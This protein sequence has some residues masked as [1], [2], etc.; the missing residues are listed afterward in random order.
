M[1]D[2]QE[3][4]QSNHFPEPEPSYGIG[5]IEE[6]ISEDIDRLLTN[7]FD[8]LYLRD[9]YKHENRSI[10]IIYPRIAYPENRSLMLGP[11]KIR[12]LLSLYPAKENLR[13]IDKIVL[14]PR[15][16]EIGS[17]ELTSLYLKE[18]GILVIYLFHPYSYPLGKGRPEFTHISLEKLA[19]QELVKDKNRS[20]SV[21]HPLWYIISV[22]GQS[23]ADGNSIEKFFIK[24]NPINDSEYRM[25]NDISYFYSQ[26]G[27]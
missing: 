24:K 14:R 23:G 6:D 10:D 9:I 2:I 27:Y 16:V 22:I 1:F 20:Q 13:F 7:R 19:Q 4:F 26:H 3:Y 21:A 5:D 15:Y 25:L 18:K 11:D 12:F 8:R 17:I